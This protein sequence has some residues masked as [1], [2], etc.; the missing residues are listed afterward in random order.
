MQH[1]HGHVAW[2][3]TCNIDMVMRIE[4]DMHGCGH[5]ACSMHMDM[6][7]GN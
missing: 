3:W 2:I 4:I 7:H 1:G 6:Q 5:A